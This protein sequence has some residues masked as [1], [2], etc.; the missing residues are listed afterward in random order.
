MQK[1]WRQA[2]RK[3][4][5]GWMSWS[6]L[7]LLDRWALKRSLEGTDLDLVQLASLELQD[8]QAV[9]RSFLQLAPLLLNQCGEY[10]CDISA[11]VVHLVSCTRKENLNFEF[12]HRK[13]CITLHSM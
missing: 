11:S 2:M 1:V 13:N 3:Q 6:Q 4:L 12:L 10:N 7:F 5:V 8:L 9:V